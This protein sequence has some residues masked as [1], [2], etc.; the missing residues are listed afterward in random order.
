MAGIP[1]KRMGSVSMNLT[2]AFDHF[3]SEVQKLQT[4]SR[5]ERISGMCTSRPN[6]VAEIGIAKHHDFGEFAIRSEEKFVE[7]PI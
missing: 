6:L 5:Q 7:M 2:I 3:S 4:Y 1:P